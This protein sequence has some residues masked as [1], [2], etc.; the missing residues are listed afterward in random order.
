MFAV[1]EI[2]GKPDYIAISQTPS[3]CDIVRSCFPDATCHHT[4]PN[5]QEAKEAINA[6]ASRMQIIEPLLHSAL[7]GATLGSEACI[8]LA[9]QLRLSP[10][11]TLTLFGDLS[12][13]TQ[14]LSVFNVLLQGGRCPAASLQ[15]MQHNVRFQLESQLLR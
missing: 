14:R 5:W 3:C 1:Y 9:S 15:Q 2:N 11:E 8:T 13:R 6:I 10:A 7:R 4:F 12:S